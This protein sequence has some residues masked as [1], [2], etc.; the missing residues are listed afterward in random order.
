MATLTGTTV[1]R[2]PDTL[3]PV[4]LAAGAELPEWAAGLVG[5]HL[6]DSGGKRLRPM[7]SRLR[8]GSSSGAFFPK[9]IRAL[10]I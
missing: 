8:R 7:K 3:A 9:A 4:V 10:S 2:H 1:V 6:I 5:D